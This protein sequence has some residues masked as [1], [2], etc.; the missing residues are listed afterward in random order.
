VIKPSRAAVFACLFVVSACFERGTTPIVPGQTGLAGAKHRIAFSARKANPD[1]KHVWLHYDYMVFPSGLDLRNVEPY[2]SIPGY[3]CVFPPGFSTAPDVQQIDQV[4]AA[5]SNQGLQLHI[6]PQHVAIPGVYAILDDLLGESWDPSPTCMGPSSAKFSDLKAQY[7]RPH[8]NHPWHYTIV[9][10]VIDSNQGELGNTTCNGLGGIAELPGFDFELA[11]G[12]RYITGLG[13]GPPQ[14]VFGGLLM[15]ELGHNLGLQHGGDEDLNWKPNYLS[16]MNYRF[17]FGI[18]QAAYLGSTQ[19][20]GNFR[21]DYSPAALATLDEN[22]LNE[23]L[24]IGA[25]TKDISYY[26]DFFGAQDCIDAYPS[27]AVPAAASGPVDWNCDGTLESDIS[28]DIISTTNEYYP[29]RAIH[30][31]DDWVEVEAM[32]SQSP[33]K[34]RPRRHVDPIGFQLPKSV[35]EVPFHGKLPRP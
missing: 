14:N 31:F 2:C 16:V 12:P 28:D 13:F 35:L 20:Y 19:P 5:F 33:S 25:G 9:G 8:G 17:Q 18:P 32:L 15:H 23:N 6:D 3:Q 10:F 22:H 29:L 7:F 34:M 27:P 30:G 26:W 1:P 24:G 21:V 11:F 4:V